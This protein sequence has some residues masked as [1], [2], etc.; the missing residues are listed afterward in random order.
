ML[1]NYI[2]DIVLCNNNTKIF[3]SNL[4]TTTSITDNLMSQ[5]IVRNPYNKQDI[6]FVSQ[7]IFDIDPV[8]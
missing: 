2:K 1:H 7:Y 8:P 5:P 4:N 6:T 3:D